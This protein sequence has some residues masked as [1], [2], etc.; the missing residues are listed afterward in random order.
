MAELSLSSIHCPFVLSC[1]E[2]SIE[3][4]CLA[5]AAISQTKIA[6]RK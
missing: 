2:T 3:L 4:C 5:A 6:A 1:A